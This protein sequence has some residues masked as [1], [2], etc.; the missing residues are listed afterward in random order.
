MAMT[1]RCRVRFMRSSGR[2][3]S[4]FW[5][6]RNLSL[7]LTICIIVCTRR[8]WFTEVNGEE[9]CYCF[10]YWSCTCFYSFTEFLYF[11][12]EFLPNPL[13]FFTITNSTNL[14]SQ[15]NMN[16]INS[17]HFLNATSMNANVSS[18]IYFCFSLIF[19]L[20]TIASTFNVSF[21]PNP[22]VTYKFKSV[23]RWYSST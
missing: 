12:T 9:I 15:K 4:L 3:R 11:F 21:S 7:R 13:F 16:A 2:M 20:I 1:G 22:N 17:N 6:W 10:F 5:I 19:S 14:K 23:S 18:K 8:R